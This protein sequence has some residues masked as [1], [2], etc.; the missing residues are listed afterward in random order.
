MGLA[1]M[2]QLTRA[3]TPGLRDTG[4][5]VGGFN[6]VVG[7]TTPMIPLAMAGM[8]IAPDR[9]GP[10][11]GRRH[12]GLIRFPAPRTTAPSC[13]STAMPPANRQGP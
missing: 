12:W 5:Y 6:P 10:P 2:H 1:E 11:L 9:L 4:F 13:N 7:I 8:R 3:E